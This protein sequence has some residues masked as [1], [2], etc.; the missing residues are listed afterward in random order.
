MRYEFHHVAISVT[1]IQASSRFYAAFGFRP[2]TSWVADDKSLEIVHLKLHEVIVE[3]FCYRDPISL[4]EHAQSLDNDLPTLGCKHFG[5]RVLS[6]RDAV[7]DLK[8]SGHE[9]VSEIK[10]GRTG[11]QYCFYRDPDGVFVEV[12]QDNRSL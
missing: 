8:R 6:I 11:I 4:P 5:L 9:P 2:L 10:L 7:D 3:L 1:D 12:V